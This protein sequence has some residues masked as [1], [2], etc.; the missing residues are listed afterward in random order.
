MNLGGARL[1]L[2]QSVSFI[3]SLILGCCAFVNNMIQM[4]EERLTGIHEH[5]FPFTSLTGATRGGVTL[6]RSA[7]G[8]S[9]ITHVRTNHTH[10][11]SLGDSLQS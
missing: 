11:E 2:S 7:G 8:E 3:P 5:L 10:R 4:C 1:E 9:R 6:Q